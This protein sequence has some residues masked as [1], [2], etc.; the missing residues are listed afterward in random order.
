[1]TQNR[2]PLPAPRAPRHLPPLHTNSERACPKTSILPHSGQGREGHPGAWEE[3]ALAVTKTP[4]LHQA[5][6]ARR[7]PRHAVGWGGYT[8]VQEL[9]PT[10]HSFFQVAGRRWT[11]WS[12]PPPVSRSFSTLELGSGISHLLNVLEG[13]VCACL[14]AKG[15][16]QLMSEVWEA[17]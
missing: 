8:E 7:V 16:C 17:R 6:M 14:M 4:Y 5:A 1:M 12:V 10:H 15:Q 3:G 2:R 9:G 11:S 13:G